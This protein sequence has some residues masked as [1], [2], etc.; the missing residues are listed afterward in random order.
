[1]PPIGRLLAD[2]AED[3]STRAL[4]NCLIAA[5][6]ALVA[7]RATADPVLWSEHQRAFFQDG[8]GL[9][10]DESER[11][12]LLHMS[13]GERERYIEEFLADPL[14]ETGENELLAAIDRRKRLA[15]IEVGTP[16]DDRA[17]LLFLNGSPLGREIVDCG[18]T[19]VP[20]EIWSYG[21]EGKEV[22]LYQAPGRSAYRLWR[23]GDGK[24]VLYS[25]LM[26]GWL[27]ELRD[28]GQEG[29]RLD[30]KLCQAV[31]RVDQA[32]GTRG[33]FDEQAT[34]GLAS[35]LEGLL[36]AP[37]D[38]AV[39]SEEASLTP[40]PDL[41]PVLPVEGVEVEFPFRSG[42]RVAARFIATLPAGAELAVVE[43][44]GDDP[45][46]EIEV[47]GLVELD[48][49]VFDEF[50]VRFRRP[51]PAADEPIALVWDQRLRPG[52]RFVTRLTIRDAAGGAVNQQVRVVAVP[53]SVE[54]AVLGGG[55]GAVPVEEVA[56]GTLAGKDSLVLVPPVI[57]GLSKGWRAEALVTGER[58]RRVVFA[59]DGDEQLIRTR[60]PYT[61]DL[62]LADVPMEQI[63]T[64]TGYDGAGDLVAEDR[65]VLNKA[66]A[67][68]RVEIVS[69]RDPR[70]STRSIVAAAEVS[71]PDEHRL[72]GVDFLLNDKPLATLVAPPFELAV[73]VDRRAEVSY[74]TV[75]AR[76]DDGRRAE[77]VLFL[78]TPRNLA[79]VD[80][81][82]VELFATVTDRSGRLVADLAE[83]DFEIL[84]GGGDRPLQRF[85]RVENL[86]L[87]VGFAL[88]AST[89]MAD[90]MA[91]AR[92][93]ATGFLRSVLQRD[94][95]AF[96]VAF[97]DQPELVA[98]PTDDVA[99]VEEALLGVHSTGWTALY[100]AVVRSL[101]YFRGFGGRRALVVLSDG[102]D[103]ASRAS[104]SETLEY[105]KQ[106][107]AVIYSIGL[108]TGA[109]G[110]LRGKLKKL[111]TET[112]GRYFQAARASDLAAVYAEIEKELRSQYFLT[113]APASPS[114]VDLS[115]VE[116]NV[117]G[118]G[119]KVRATRGYAP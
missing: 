53:R 7:A 16:L 17:R 47:E 119:L 77:D 95:R 42:Q 70:G 90:H 43:Q 78:D 100:D 118:R 79:R 9:L 36:S 21:A 115:A 81:G 113:F 68:F 45:E 87:V 64:A 3:M 30:V 96:A 92:E 29:R 109:G 49:R 18:T 82:L 67:L 35:F 91:E 2:F 33:L 50:K 71:V 1:M 28:F 5:L 46:V 73:D 59:V 83:E 99:V 15:R 110:G 94:D 102:E 48:G 57:D 93:A 98:P 74:L 38:I 56:A 117:R 101:F 66:R 85:D 84:E 23:P 19:L 51:P 13:D 24:R 55:G 52:R 80:V 61:A 69:P 39:W 72:E 11:Q 103:T 114:R 89:S 10:L 104:F 111:A 41:P 107:G 26:E 31:V 65:V 86:P 88:D 25:P 60:P 14:P 75:V 32:T 8:P 106:S 44:E 20:T 34:A 97:N 4:A 105:A 76:L 22:V 12:L 108:G 6:L 37:E 116:V 62:R 112:G 54:R 27:E 58:I 40:L 63:V